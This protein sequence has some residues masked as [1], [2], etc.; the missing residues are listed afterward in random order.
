MI[1]K[2]YSENFFQYYLHTHDYDLVILSKLSVHLSVTPKTIAIGKESYKNIQD[3]HQSI[4]LSFLLFNKHLK[5]QVLLARFHPP[6]SLSKYYGLIY[7]TI[8]ELRKN[9]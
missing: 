1:D 7:T 9:T 3:L 8:K 2:V 4:N 6:G 5:N